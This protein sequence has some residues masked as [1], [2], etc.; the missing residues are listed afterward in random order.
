VVDHHAIDYSREA[1]SILVEDVDGSLVVAAKQILE[2]EAGS[3]LLAVDE[4]NAGRKTMLFLHIVD[5]YIHNTGSHRIHDCVA[6]D[7]SNRHRGRDDV[8]EEV[9]VLVHVVAL[10]RQ[11]RFGGYSSRFGSFVELATRVGCA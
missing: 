4:A 6:L 2:A 1:D 7:G 8:E 3:I 10:Y 5:K 9:D 11:P